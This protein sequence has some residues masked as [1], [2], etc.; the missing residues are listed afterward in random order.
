MAV[1]VL[2]VLAAPLVYTLLTAR[3]YWSALFVAVVVA[4]GVFLPDYATR[5]QR[6]AKRKRDAETGGS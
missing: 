3:S 4:L 5:G 2:L 6:E 1:I